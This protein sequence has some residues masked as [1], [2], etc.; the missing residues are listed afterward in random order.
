LRTTVFNTPQ[1]QALARLTGTDTV[2]ADQTW[3]YARRDNTPSVEA[4]YITEKSQHSVTITRNRNSTQNDDYNQTR[5]SR[6]SQ[7]ITW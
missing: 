7:T 1:H 2:S 5:Y 4:G 6:R 3:Y